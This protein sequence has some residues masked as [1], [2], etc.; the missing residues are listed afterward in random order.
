MCHPSD[1]EYMLVD[2]TWDIMPL[3]G[4][5]PSILGFYSLVFI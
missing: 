4:I 5:C 1:E 3:S 2:K